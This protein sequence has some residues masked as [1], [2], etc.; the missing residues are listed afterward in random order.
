MHGQSELTKECCTAPITLEPPN[1][2]NACGNIGASL[3]HKILFDREIPLDKL[4]PLDRVVAG[5]TPQSLLII[6]WILHV[7]ELVGHCLRDQTQVLHN[8]LNPRHATATLGYGLQHSLQSVEARPREPGQMLTVA[9]V[10]SSRETAPATA[11]GF[12]GLSNRSSGSR[13][14]KPRCVRHACTRHR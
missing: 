5:K 12:R 9:C 7:C 11:R 8:E 6:V 2:D 4:L 10:Q 3:F 14:L 13:G 1:G